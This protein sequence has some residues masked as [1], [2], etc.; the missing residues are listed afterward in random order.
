MI[1]FALT[2]LFQPH[3]ISSHP[4]ASAGY[5]AA[6]ELTSKLQ[7]DLDSTGYLK[8]PPGKTELTGLFVPANALIEGSGGEIDC[9]NG[10]GGP[11]FICNNPGFRIVNVTM[12]GF[13]TGILVN[14]DQPKDGT[15]EAMISGCRIYDYVG[16]VGI[17]WRK[18]SDGYI[19][20]CV[21]A[22]TIGSAGGKQNPYYPS[23]AITSNTARAGIWLDAGSGGVVVSD[24]HTWGNNLFD[25]ADYGPDTILSNDRME[26]GRDAH[27]LLAGARIQVD[28]GQ[29]WDVM[30]GTISAGVQLGA[31]KSN[32][33]NSFGGEATYCVIRDLAV[34]GQGTLP[35]GTIRFVREGHNDIRIFTPGAA[36]GPISTRGAHPKDRVEIRD[37]SK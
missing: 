2:L 5:Q 4:M 15:G 16:G 35:G 27:L 19:D 14:S 26:G 34:G 7:H 18:L 36:S 33:A 32:T 13:K 3:H 20:H 11:A 23:P 31:S 28:G 9:A 25:I 21:I 1:T 8:L 12:R 24:C 30:N 17:D 37:L 22:N 10:Y 6:S 29:I